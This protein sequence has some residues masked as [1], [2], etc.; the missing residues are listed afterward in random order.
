[1]LRRASPL[2]GESSP[3]PLERKCLAGMPMS[4]DRSSN[5]CAPSI[6][7][8]K[9]LPKA[10]V[11]EEFPGSAGG[12]PAAR[13]SSVANGDIDPGPP[14]LPAAIGSLSRR[15][16]YASLSRSAVRW[17]QRKLS[18][19]ARKKG[20]APDVV[21]A[22]QAASRA[23]VVP[24]H[25]NAR[26]AEGLVRLAQ[27]SHARATADGA[28]NVEPFL[29]VASSRVWSDCQRAHNRLP[30]NLN[31]CLRRAGQGSLA[32]SVPGPLTG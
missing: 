13:A 2:C 12:P 17:R 5:T 21:G 30:K 3:A 28:P 6:A 1:T 23:A 9:D 22:L 4:R 16:R 26:R 19:H 8:L 7:D 32:A 25:R 11:R 10:A 14:A 15:S 18:R 20:L 27:Q 31:P 29:H 24:L